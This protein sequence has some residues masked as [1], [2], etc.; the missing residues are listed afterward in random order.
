MNV[1]APAPQEAPHHVTREPGAV[2]R[3]IESMVSFGPGNPTSYGWPELAKHG[4]PVRTGEE[5]GRHRTPY[6]V[7]PLVAVVGEIVRDSLSWLGNKTAGAAGLVYDVWQIGV[8]NPLE[9]RADRTVKLNA[10][11]Y[12]SAETQ[13]SDNTGKPYS[14]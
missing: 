14:G 11:Q 4:V 9:R 2:G 7:E 13:R 1:L 6:E 10:E 3:A 8:A 5:P 12:Y